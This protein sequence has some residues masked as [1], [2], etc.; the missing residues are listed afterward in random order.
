MRKLAWFDNNG[1][2]IDLF[3]PVSSV[4]LLLADEPIDET[5]DTTEPCVTNTPHEVAQII[6]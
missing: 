1:D 6:Y 4:F 2:M 3:A 5:M